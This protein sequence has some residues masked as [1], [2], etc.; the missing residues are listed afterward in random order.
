MNLGELLEFPY[1][2]SSAIASLVHKK[3]EVLGVGEVYENKSNTDSTLAE[4]LSA[5][6]SLKYLYL[7]VTFLA[8]HVEHLKSTSVRDVEL[9]H[10]DMCSQFPD[11]L[12]ILVH[13]QT[14]QRLALG[15]FLLS[16]QSVDTMRPLVEAI[17]KNT[18][19]QEI[20]LLI[21][22]IR[23]SNEHVAAYMAAHHEPLTLD[24]RIMWRKHN[25]ERQ[26]SIQSSFS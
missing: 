22:G 5:P 4:V 19:L 2:Y 6:S 3:L 7:L 24:S 20:T 23:N 16:K 8:P 26:F 25:F 15:Q 11:L 12:K 1:G 14:I 13:N 9:V 10:A 21:D 17:N 18:T